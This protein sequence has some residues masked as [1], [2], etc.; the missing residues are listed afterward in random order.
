LHVV[1]FFLLVSGSFSFFCWLVF[2]AA[3]DMYDHMNTKL[4]I[5]FNDATVFCIS[6]SL[7][8]YSCTSQHS[9]NSTLQSA[10]KYQALTSRIA[11]HKIYVASLEKMV[12]HGKDTLQQL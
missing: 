1:T 7:M 3:V 2:W 4:S 9:N 8:P 10:A 12:R 11:P 6:V 5:C